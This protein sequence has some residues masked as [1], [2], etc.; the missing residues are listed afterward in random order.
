MV[1]EELE[2]HRL[3]C[4]GVI[5][6]TGPDNVRVAKVYRQEYRDVLLELVYYL[7][8]ATREAEIAIQQALHGKGPL[9]FG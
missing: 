6:S 2:D 3:N 5:E 1:F 8:K 9:N 4:V 7:R